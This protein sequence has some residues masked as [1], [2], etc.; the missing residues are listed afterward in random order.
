MY[1]VLLVIHV[2]ITVAMIAII[3]LQ[4]NAS[5]GLSG[6]GGGGGGG[7]MTSRGQ[8][9]LLTR[10]TAILATLFIVNSLALGWLTHRSLPSNSIA[11]QIV[12][13]QKEDAVMV[14]TPDDVKAE[15]VKPEATK[16]EK[17]TDKKVEEKVPAPSNKTSEKKAQ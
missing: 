12:E 8:A 4:R 15:A 11:D 3:L 10:M 13:K 14:P 2:I 5:D 7:F 17:N 6:I 9:N 1:H 16:T